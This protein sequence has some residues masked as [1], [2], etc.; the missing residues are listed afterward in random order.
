MPQTKQPNFLFLMADQLTAFALR[1]YGNGVCRTPNLDRL[2]ARSTRFANMYCNFPLCA[3]SRVAMLTG[4][5]PSS[6]GVYDNASEFSA[7]VPTFLHHLALAG[8]STIL[9]GK[10]HFVGPEQHHGF[11]ERLTTDIYPSDFGW[12]PDW[13]EE[14]PIAPTGMNMRSVIEAGE[15]RRSMQIDY[16]DDVVYRGVQKIYD[17]GRLHRDRPF[18][19]AVSM[20]HPHNPYVSTREFLDLYRP[21]DIDMPAV[22]PIPFDAQDPHSQRLWYMFRQDEY[23]VGDEH[24]RAARH[25]YYAMVSYVDAQVGRLLDALQA[26]DL[27]ES[28]VVVF[29]ADHGDML[30]ERGL[31]YKWVHFD[32]AV[33]I[34]LLISAPG[35]TRPAVRHELASLVDIFPTMLELAGVSVPDDGASP[36]PD[37]RSL[38]QGLGVSQ[39]EPTGV[40][41]G[42]MNGEGA[43]APCLAVRQGWWKLV[44]AEGDPPL[45]FNLQDDPHELRNLAGQPAARDIERQLTALVHAKWDAAGLHQD[46]LHSQARRR[47]VQ[48]SRLQGDFPAWDY[49][50]FTDASRQ[51]VRAGAQSSPALVKGKL[52]YPPVAPTAPQHP[53]PARSNLPE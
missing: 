41:Y 21:E 14:I 35:H 8:Y 25:A 2:A 45:L 32:P 16:D 33:R 11:Q 22:P 23:E 1:M 48:Q 44:V 18:F 40:V 26:M 37:G 3:P 43:H 24:V 30:G 28:T 27:D 52:R 17:L 10:M 39:D 49:Q 29:T 34:P 6:V 47:L 7:E 19:L 42:E 9:S 12:T 15:C 4:R 53:R 13:R 36:P 20:T 46:I 38:A 31:W 5:L 50:P 51:Y